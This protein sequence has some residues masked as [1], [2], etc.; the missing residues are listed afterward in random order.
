MIALKPYLVFVDNLKD[1][2]SPLTNISYLVKI[3]ENTIFKVN[4]KNRDA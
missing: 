3:I 4:R 1:I 2:I